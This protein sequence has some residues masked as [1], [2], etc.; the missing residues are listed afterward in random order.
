M[1]TAEIIE[2]EKITLVMFTDDVPVERHLRSMFLTIGLP[3][4]ENK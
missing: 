4:E 3:K 1:A 2:P